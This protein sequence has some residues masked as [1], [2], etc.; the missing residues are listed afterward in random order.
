MMETIELKINYLP[1]IKDGAFSIFN[2]KHSIYPR[3]QYLQTYAKERM[4]DK[5][6]FKGELGILIENY[7]C[8]SDA[9][10]IIGGI[11]DSL[12]KIVFV[13][14]D[15]FKEVNYR[16]LDKEE[17]RKYKVKIWKINDDKTL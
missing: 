5:K 3:V 15:Q 6:I 11:F 16:L 2:K 7:G 1:P 13:N 9:D 8:R 4:K 14:D 17:D 12:E 10:N